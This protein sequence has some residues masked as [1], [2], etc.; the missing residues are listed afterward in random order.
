MLGGAPGQARPAVI[1]RP[2]GRACCPGSSVPSRSSGCRSRRPALPPLRHT[3]RRTGAPGARCRGR[4]GSP[5]RG[6]A[7][8]PE[9]LA[10]GSGGGADRGGFL[11]DGFEGPGGPR[12]H[13]SRGPRTGFAPM[14]GGH[15]IDDGGVPV[16]AAGAQMRGGLSGI[17]CAASAAP[18]PRVGRSGTARCRSVPRPRRGHRCRP[19]GLPPTDLIGGPSAHGL[20]RWAFRPRT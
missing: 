18:R 16:I 20:D 3:R 15:V 7:G 5:V 17:P 9:Q 11:V 12:V 2:G 10:P 13:A 1:A 19:V 4:S 8:A 14:A 6:A